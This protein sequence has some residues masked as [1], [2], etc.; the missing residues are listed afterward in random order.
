[1]GASGI[2]QVLR[3]LPAG[4]AVVGFVVLLACLMS[5]CT[6]VSGLG[7]GSGSWGGLHWIDDDPAWIPGGDSFVFTSNRGASPGQISVDGGRWSLYVMKLGGRAPR[8]LTAPTHGCTDDYAAPSPDGRL[9]AFVRDCPST[10]PGAMPTPNGDLPGQLM[11][12][13]TAGGRAK[14]LATGLDVYSGTTQVEWSADGRLI[15]YAR[16]RNPDDPTAPDDLWTA[17][18]RTGALR[19][20]GRDVDG[21]AWSRRGRR[22]A[23][24][25]PGDVCVVSPPSGVVHRLHRFAADDAYSFAWSADDTQLAFVDGSGGSYE[26]DYSAWV[27]N[28]DGTNAHRLPRYGEGNVDAVQWLP[29]QPRALVVNTDEAS[30]YRIQS[31]GTGKR[32]FPIEVDVV[33]PSPD[34]RTLLFVRRV[35]DSD[36]NYYR[37]AISVVDVRSGRVRRLTQR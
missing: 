22:L 17:D 23:F 30:L 2:H 28:G 26:P 25:C 8:R 1:M 20:V 29:R 14:R 18:V 7:S 16:M 11:V 37:S 5:G 35:F 4:A 32:D 33:S 34:G 15:A 36:G 9:V 13:P 31:D 10:S 12:V 3:G 6:V 24:G 19:R 27:M 21:F